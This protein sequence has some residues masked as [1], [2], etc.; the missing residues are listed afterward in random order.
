[1]QLENGSE[2]QKIEKSCVWENGRLGGQK[3][4]EI[5]KNHIS[6]KSKV[7]ALKKIGSLAPLVNFLAREVWPDFPEW[8]K[9]GLGGFFGGLEVDLGQK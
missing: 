2:R 4:P 8:A 6:R 7:S 5:E 3:W 1:V 9:M